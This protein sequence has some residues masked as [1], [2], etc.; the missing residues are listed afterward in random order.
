MSVSTAAVIAALV[1]GAACVPP[2]VR[3]QAA[4]DARTLQPSFAP[5]TSPDGTS[6]T[7]APSAGAA[8]TAGA[9]PDPGAGV[10]AAAPTPTVGESGTGPTSRPPEP[11]P[12]P[13]FRAS[14]RL[15]DPTGDVEE[16]PLADAP[17]Y[18]DLVVAALEIDGDT[19]TLSIRLGADTPEAS[20][21]GHTMNVASFYDVDGDGAIDYEVWANL[22]PDGWGTSWFD[23]RERRALYGADDEV[24][25]TATPDA[26]VLRFPHSYLGDA[27]VFRWALASEWGSYEALSTGLMTSDHAPDD[28]AP[29]RFPG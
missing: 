26:L 19:A 24:E 6:P 20:E 22:S 4:T 25:V 16:P 11:A 23:N 3:D 8:P 21:D 1:V 2:A 9:T 13:P 12:P 17:P 27:E 5:A 28:G 7:A 15:T 18:A 10:Q 14:A 29:A